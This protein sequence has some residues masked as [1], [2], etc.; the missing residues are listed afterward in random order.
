M[1]LVLSQFEDV[2]A[3]IGNH[4]ETGEIGFDFETTGLRPYQGDRAFLL[5]FTHVDGLKY[6]FD[7]RG[8]PNPES[9]LIILRAMQALFSNPRIKYCAHNAKFELA[10]LHEQ[11]SV[12]VAGEVWDSE[13]MAR[14][15]RNSHLS[16]SLQNC[17]LRI[18]ETKYPPMLEW[19]KIRGNKNNYAGAPRDIIVPYV[20]QDAWL[21][22]RLRRHQVE[23]F[24]SWDIS[25][26]IKIKPV[27]RLEANVLPHLFEME[28]N[29][30]LVDVNYC[31]RAV[32]YEKQQ[33]ADSK[34]AFESLAAVP[35]VDSRKTLRPVFDAHGIRYG[36]T[37]L[38]NA[39]FTEDALV[40]DQGHPVVTALLGHRRAVKRLSAY[41]ENFLELEQNGIIHPSIHS[42]KAVTG[43][44]SISDPS[45]QNWSTD[46]DETTAFP[47]R[48]AFI[49]REGCL[50]ASLDYS[51]M[52]LRKSADE[53]D[54][55]PMIERIKSGA[56]LHQ[57]VADMAGVPRSLAKN[58][59]FAKQ[60]GAGV[61]EIAATLGV[62]E[63]VARTISDAIDRQAAATARYSRALS[64]VCKPFGTDWLGRRFYFDPGFEYK[65]FNYRIQGGSAEI[66]K[67]AII[68]VA[69]FLKKS[70]RPETFMLVVIHDEIVL[71]LDKRDLPLLPEIRR[72]MVGAHRDKRH[73]EMDVSVAVGPN[74][75]DLQEHR[76]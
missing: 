5:G 33:I 64:R 72:I 71:N 59:R 75:Y 17:A 23:V 27:V 8:Y 35:F 41:W 11:F 34:A 61:P 43:R 39:S 63:A 38:G 28:R 50:I 3:G 1:E 47:I 70:A 73:L 68:D 53:A 22:W 16:Y 49:A 18:G 45:A 52:E 36:A 7:F 9:E 40:G 44:M 14:V 24:K 15:E 26:P 6:S 76:L 74:F 48:R 10:F 69:N 29:G 54:D 19:L 57:E 32:E 56:D 25:S 65:A 51:Q 42:N 46:E 55:M 12:S 30:L 66:L 4:P 20:E 37:A 21:S 67:I 58:G 2:A 60:Y 62:S 13:T 31:M